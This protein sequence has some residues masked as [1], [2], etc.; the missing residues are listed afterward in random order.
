MVGTL[1]SIEAHLGSVESDRSVCYY[2][3]AGYFAGIAIQAR[4]DIHGQDL[5]SGGSS[6]IDFSDQIVG[7]TAWRTPETRSEQGV[8]NES[9]LRGLSGKGPAGQGSEVQ[10]EFS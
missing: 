6:F 9:D 5:D 7:R 2:R 4:G 1:S 8:H 10:L 3:H